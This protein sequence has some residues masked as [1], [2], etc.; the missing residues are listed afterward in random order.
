M[1][2]PPESFASLARSDEDLVKTK[3]PVMFLHKRRNNLAARPI[4]V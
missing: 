2:L 1:I 4:Q 3:S